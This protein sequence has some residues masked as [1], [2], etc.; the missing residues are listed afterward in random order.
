MPFEF[1]GARMWSLVRL[2]LPAA[3]QI[4]LE[5][6]VFATAAA[7]AA[8]I[9]PM[10][11]AANQI[12][13]NIVSFFFM[14][15]LR[16]QF[17]GGGAGRPGRRPT[18]PGRRASGRVERPRLV[19]RVRA[20]HVAAVSRWRQGRCSGS[21]PTTRR[22]SRSGRVLLLIC[23]VFQPFD[24]FQVVSTG[25]LRGLGDT[26]TPMCSTW[27]AHWLIGLPIGYWLCFRRG[28]GVEGLW[29]GLSLSLILIGA[30]LLGVWHRKEKVGTGLAGAS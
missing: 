11:L 5:V 24:G 14:V 29:A 27:S 25:A 9:T 3:L 19:A 23:A 7:L 30:A 15:P 17:G 10:A 20:R 26:K 22:S 13:L 18:R 16:A 28:W 8:R 1:E 2:G 6:G 21:S 4:T 12:V